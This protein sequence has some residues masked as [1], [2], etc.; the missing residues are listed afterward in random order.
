V[1]LVFS[2]S[3]GSVPYGDSSDDTGFPPRSHP[4]ARPRRPAVDGKVSAD[5]RRE[6]VDRGSHLT[7]GRIETED[8]HEHALKWR[9]D[10]LRARVIDDPHGPWFELDR[11][12]K[13]ASCSTV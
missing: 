8:S 2:G 13:N 11:R 5:E 9:A 6:S 4:R 3:D 12:W 10:D 1:A 7:V